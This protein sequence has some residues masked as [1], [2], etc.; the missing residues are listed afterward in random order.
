MKVTLLPHDAQRRTPITRRSTLTLLAASLAAPSWAQSATALPASIQVMGKTFDKQNFRLDQHKGK[1]VLLMFWSTDCAVCRDKMR[2][3]RDNAAGWADQPFELVLV[4]T[5]TRMGDV[6]AY[7]TI[8]NK[9]VKNPN[10]RFMQLWL[11]DAD[12]K[13]NLNTASLTR[14]QL[15]LAFVIDKKG[16]PVK[17]YQGRIPAQAWDDIADLL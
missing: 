12:Y 7:N 15:P 3:L 16:K 13:D 14:A 11:R 17:R 9:S 2:E 1:V 6:D 4:S 10:Q 5:D 8:L